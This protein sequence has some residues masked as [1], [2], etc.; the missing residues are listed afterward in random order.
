MPP[1]WP[2]VRHPMDAGA[3]GR[4]FARRPSPTASFAFMDVRNRQTPIDRIAAAWCVV[5]SALA[6]AVRH[7]SARGNA[8]TPAALQ[9][10]GCIGVAMGG[11][12]VSRARRAR[13][14]RKRGDRPQRTNRE[15]ESQRPENAHLVPQSLLAGAGW[16]V[17]CEHGIVCLPYLPRGYCIQGAAGHRRFR[18]RH[19]FVHC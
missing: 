8:S 15:G 13:I 18:A 12:A 6:R 5:C 3:S 10:G 11:V 17:T 2:W 16:S 7:S 1:C 14:L 19:S 4:E 9:R